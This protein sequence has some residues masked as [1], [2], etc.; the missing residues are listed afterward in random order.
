MAAS[1]LLLAVSMRSSS[2]LAAGLLLLSA[3]AFFGDTDGSSEALTT[4]VD[5]P[6]CSHPIDRLIVP[7]L[8][9]ARV[10][11]RDGDAASVCR[12]MSVDLIGRIPTEGELH[13]CVSEPS[14]DRRADAFMA[15]PEYALVQQRGWAEALGFN[16]YLLWYGYAVDLDALAGRLYRPGDDGTTLDYATFAS[17]IAPHPAFYGLHQG[18]DW[19]ASIFNV[20]LGRSARA[21][22]IASMRPLVKVFESRVFCDAGIWVD[23]YNGALADNRSA[24]DATS[25]ANDQCVAGGTEEFVFDFC[26]CQRGEGSIGCRSEALGALVDLGQDGCDHPDSEEETA[27]YRRVEGGSVPGTRTT[28]QGQP[29]QD[30]VVDDTEHVAGVLA[31]LPTIAPAQ[32]EKI[33]LIGKALVA[34]P[35]FWEAGADRELGRFIGWWKDGV[36]RPDFDLPEVRT[37]LADE[38]RRTGSVRTIQKLIVTSLLY[39]APAEPPPD[40]HPAPGATGPAMDPPLWSMGSTKLLTSESWLDSAGVATFGQVLGACDYRFVAIGE[41][42]PA[43]V[44]P[45]FVRRVAAPDAARFTSER[46]DLSAVLLGGCSAEQPRPKKSTVGITYA[47]HDLARSLCAST[48]LIGGSDDMRT[49]IASLVRRTLSRDPSNEEIALLAAEAGQCRAAPGGCSS[50]EAAMRWLCSRIVDSAAFALY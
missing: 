21:D 9:A 10:A 50:A 42:G 26:G 22:E 7:K 5:D 13:R 6:H 48:P 15:M 2:L 12:R 19:A 32:R 1:P 30:E 29:C 8:R 27:S 49:A 11:P 45:T 43:N 41:T 3:C 35:D 40:F 28:C 38:L 23:A 39:A 47:Q 44:D 16:A 17:T 4:C 14:L 24:A 20:F 25:D 31:A 46:Y 33:D 18:D 36:R 37:V 34:R